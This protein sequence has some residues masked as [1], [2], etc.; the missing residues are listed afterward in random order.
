MIKQSKEGDQT[1][2]E[3]KK[4]IEHREE[5]QLLNEIRKA[6][7]ESLEEEMRLAVASLN[8][9]LDLLKDSQAALSR[10]QIEEKILFDHRERLNDAL[11]AARTHS[12]GHASFSQLSDSESHSRSQKELSSHASHNLDWWL[13]QSFFN[14]SEMGRQLLDKHIDEITEKVEEAEMEL[15]QKKAE[16]GEA[17]RA[18]ERQAH[19]RAVKEALDNLLSLS[20]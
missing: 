7:P 2:K 6:T 9:A 3:V 20:G 15:G 8:D 4:I 11:E 17:E 19:K 13:N 10:L 5:K 1:L 14:G 12:A 16:V 18:V